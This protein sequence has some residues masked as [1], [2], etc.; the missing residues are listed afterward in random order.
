MEDT[1]RSDRTGR[2]AGRKPAFSA[3]DVVDAALAEGIDHFTLSAV[4]GRLGVATPAIY[5]LY[6]SRDDIVD[7]ALDVIAES[8]RHPEI[9][10]HWRDVLQLWSD[11]IWR[12]CETYHGLNRV[13]YSYPTAFAHIEDAIGVYAAALA[14][15]GKSPGQAMF[16]LD[17][18]GDTVMSSHLGVE[19]MRSVDKDQTRALDRVREKISG[20]SAMAPDEGWADRYFMDAKVGFVITALADNWP[21]APT[22]T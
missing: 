21:E 9:G 4:A 19:A 12:I 1:R 17:F 11:E 10:A 3:R 18:L 2:R 22:T 15:N 16:A 13:V 5:R 14:A 7:A 8:I 6:R 20:A